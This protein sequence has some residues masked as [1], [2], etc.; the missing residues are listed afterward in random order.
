MT[1]L[2]DSEDKRKYVL[3]S[4]EIPLGEAISEE[5]AK[6]METLN[7]RFLD[8]LLA[9]LEAAKT[10]HLKEKSEYLKEL[11]EAY[12]KTKANDSERFK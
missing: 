2:Y 4:Y 1:K 12:A 7:K 6:E 3:K 8:G 5:E 11:E 9:N 10:L